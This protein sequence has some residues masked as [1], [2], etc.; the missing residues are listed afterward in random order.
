MNKAGNLLLRLL[1][2]IFSIEGVLQENIDAH[3][4]LSGLLCKTLLGC[5]NMYCS[6]FCQS[7]THTYKFHIQ[8]MQH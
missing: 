5:F 4:Y 1:T 2:V 3:F 7:L 8:M 6:T